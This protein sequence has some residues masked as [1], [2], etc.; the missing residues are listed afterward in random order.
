[1]RYNPDKHHRQSIRLK[2]YDYSQEGAYLI[3]ICCYN[4]R[5]LFGE[6]YRG[7]MYLNGYGKI[8]ET[9]WLKTGKIRHNVELDE[10]VIMPNHVHGIIYI[11]D[12]VGAHCNV[13]LQGHAQRNIS[14]QTERFGKSTH[15]S[16]PTIIKLFKST[17]TK[18]I[19]QL[20]STP[21]LSVWQR[22]YYE[23][24]IRNEQELHKIRHYIFTNPL[25]WQN[26][27]EN[28]NNLKAVRK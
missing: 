27:N 13:P 16:I 8:V 19:N 15:N 18:Q 12:V 22:N 1:M 6:I 20:R 28:P 4:R 26:D 24:I 25:Q 21:G 7:K 3:T 14:A 11:T 10:Y 17:V 2:G 23:H 5:C 9:E